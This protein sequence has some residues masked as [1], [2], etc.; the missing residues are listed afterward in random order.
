[1][2]T[3]TNAK[4]FHVNDLQE[5]KVNS[6]RAKILVVEDIDV[7]QE[8][9]FKLLTKLECDCEIA[10]N[11]IEALQKC[12]LTPFDLIFMD[13]QMPELDGYAATVQIRTQQ[14]SNNKIPIIAMTALSQQDK[15]K[16]LA[17]GMDDYLSKP[18][19]L[20]SL[21]K[22]LNKWLPLTVIAPEIH[23][24]DI[25]FPAANVL[26][27]Q[28]LDTAK[29]AELKE[30]MGEDFYGLLDTYLSGSQD[31]IDALQ[32]AVQNSDI[33]SVI[34]A[35]HSLKG[36]SSNLGALYLAK[37]CDELARQA[38]QDKNNNL[39]DKIDLIVKEYQEVRASLQTFY[40]EY[41]SL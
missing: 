8:L 35:A 9:M 29:L 16:C 22:M 17:A 10:G 25:H 31:R 34:Q 36:T 26:N 27:R 14:N 7:N 32:A 5:S 3:E 13:C 6:R 12:R 20:D 37:L 28:H 4:K 18:F 2:R 41:I 33:K 19:S 21:K 39:I 15:T 23:A 30:L 11:G 1:M 38:Q 24:A 40:Q